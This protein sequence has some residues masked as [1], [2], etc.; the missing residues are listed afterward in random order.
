M[1]NK[2]YMSTK[3][4]FK[5]LFA[6]Y[7]ELFRYARQSVWQLPLYALVCIVLPLLLS[8]IPAVAIEMLTQGDLGRYVFGISSLLA[9]STVLTI[10]RSF[11]GNRFDLNV[12]GMRLQTFCARL[13]HKCLTMDFCNLEPAQQQ[14]KMF[15]GMNSVSNNERGV[16]GLTRYS[17]QLFYGIFGLLS[18]GTIMFSM[19]WSV[20]VIVALTTVVT[21]PCWNIRGYRWSMGKISGFIMWSIGFGTF[22][23]NRSRS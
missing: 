4:M 2:D 10:I 13:L 12:M 3:R 9:A 22:L 8:A 11:L 20:L 14:K 15:R 7:R 5:N 18:Y 1:E 19:H 23:T 21:I 16:E 6:V 17:F